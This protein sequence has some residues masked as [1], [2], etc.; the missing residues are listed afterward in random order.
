MLYGDERDIEL[1]EEPALDAVAM[2]VSQTGEKQAGDSH[3]FGRYPQRGT[4]YRDVNRTDAAL[5][6]GAYATPMN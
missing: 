3:V 6:A 4:V 5:H 1:I 2:A